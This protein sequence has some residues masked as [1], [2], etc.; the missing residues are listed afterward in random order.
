[1]N[2]GLLGSGNLI[3]C[4]PVA[5]MW[6][7]P[8]CGRPFDFQNRLGYSTS[9]RNWVSCVDCVWATRF[10][11]TPRHIVLHHWKGRSIGRFAV[12]CSPG[13]WMKFPNHF[14]KTYDRSRAPRLSIV[15]LFFKRLMFFWF[16]NI[17]YHDC[18]LINH[19]TEFRKHIRFLDS[20]LQ[21]YWLDVK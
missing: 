1:M 7:D 11:E 14:D 12:I 10:V 18:T 16:L 17:L 19:K 4:H 15:F 2:C 13:I 3:A 5:S 21:I 6:I 20:L 9:F 8:R